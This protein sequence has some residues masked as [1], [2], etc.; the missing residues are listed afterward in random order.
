VTL[1]IPDIH[2]TNL[3]TAPEGI[4]AAEVAKKAL[5]AVEEA[6]TATIARDANDLAKKAADAAKT[7]AQKAADKLKG[8]IRMALN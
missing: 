2:L 1:P 7:A 3:G 6:S 8:L 5:H 4:T